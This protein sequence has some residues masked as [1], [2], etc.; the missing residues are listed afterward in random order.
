M[1]PWRVSFAV[2]ALGLASCRGGTGSDL[3][4]ADEAAFDSSE[5]TSSSSSASNTGAGTLPFSA[6]VLSAT[7]V[8]GTETGS[9]TLQGSAG[10]SAPT[11]AAAPAAIASKSFTGS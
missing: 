3:Y 9:A 2:I 6:A 10:A 1:R 4:P 11:A 8:D 5:A 7:T